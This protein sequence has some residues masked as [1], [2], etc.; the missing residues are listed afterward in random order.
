MKRNL[1]KMQQLAMYIIFTAATMAMGCAT[2]PTLSSHIEGGGV[3]LAVDHEDKSLLWWERPGFNWHRYHKLMIDPVTVRMETEK[4]GRDI[5]PEDLAAFIEEVS[6][7]FSQSLAPDYPVVTVPGPD[8]LRIRTVI[9]D[10]DIAKPAVNLV[11]TLVA[12]VPMD[13]GG[14]SIE[15]EFLDAVTGERLAVMADRKSGSPLQLKAGFS[16]FGYAKAAFNQWADELK[17]ALAENP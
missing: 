1:K 15:V 5:D 7:T 17:T 3:K 13:M 16:K 4:K 12:F 8:V 10:I 6:A 14:A 9:T 2:A 11:T